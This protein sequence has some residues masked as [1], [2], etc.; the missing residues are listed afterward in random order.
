MDW[1]LEVVVLPVADVDRSLA[2]YAE[3]VG[4]VVDV[5]R[6]VSDTMRIVQL[7]PPGSA[8]SVTFG[9]GLA[10]TEPGSVKGLQISV[11]DVEAA[12]SQLAE[13][14]VDVTEVR[15]VGEDGTWAPGKGGPWNSFCFFDDPD[16]NGW[17]LQERP[18][19][20]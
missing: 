18:S 12:R 16:G 3:Q 20:P 5:D 13:R 14:G 8:C 11:S 10:S 9:T 4:F 15:H 19:G 1:K 6:Q 7:T 17:A 2:F